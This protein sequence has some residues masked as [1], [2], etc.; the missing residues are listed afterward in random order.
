MADGAANALGYCYTLPDSTLPRPWKL[1]IDGSSGARYYWNT[2]TNVTQYERPAALVPPVPS[3]PRPS[4]QAHQIYSTYEQQ[5]PPQQGFNMPLSH[6]GAHI[7]QSQRYRHPLQ[8]SKQHRGYQLNMNQPMPPNVTKRPPNPCWDWPSVV[9]CVQTQGYL[10]TGQPMPNM[11]YQRN[12]P[13]Q[14]PP[15]V[16]LQ[17]QHLQQYQARFTQR[18]GAPNAQN[19]SPIRQTGQDAQHSRP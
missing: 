1:A 9:N 10:F 2:E 7:D 8:Q 13:Q 17:P 15:N 3:D 12:M 16:R 4:L 18:D 19:A 5:F 14:R 6:Q 11:G